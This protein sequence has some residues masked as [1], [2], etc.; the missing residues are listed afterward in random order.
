MLEHVQRRKGL[1]K[2]EKNLGQ[3]LIELGEP[4]WEIQ[5]KAL[6]A[7]IERFDKGSADSG[8]KILVGGSEGGVNSGPTFSK[9]TTRS[10][11]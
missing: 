9:G 5:A 6:R 11:N 4:I 2:G 3:W 8:P 10:T 7:L 1:S